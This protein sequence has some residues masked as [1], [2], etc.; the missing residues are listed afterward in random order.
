MHDVYSMQIGLKYITQ[1]VWK[2]RDINY[3]VS[4]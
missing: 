1:N 3:S 4:T 2:P